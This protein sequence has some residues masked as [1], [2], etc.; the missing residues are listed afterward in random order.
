MN[1]RYSGSSKPE[2]LAK[3]RGAERSL[4]PDTALTW[5]AEADLAVN[6]L[7]NITGLGAAQALE[8]KTGRSFGPSIAMADLI[9]LKEG[10]DW[11]N[12]Y[13][14][15]LFMAA[16]EINQALPKSTYLSR[17][18]RSLMAQTSLMLHELRNLALP[19]DFTAFDRGNPERTEQLMQQAM[20]IIPTA[21][22]NYLY[23]FGNQI[24]IT[25]QQAIVMRELLKNPGTVVSHGQLWQ[26]LNQPSRQSYDKL[27]SLTRTKLS[28][29]GLEDVIDTIPTVGFRLDPHLN[30][31]WLLHR[32]YLSEK[33]QAATIILNNEFQQRIAEFPTVAYKGPVRTSVGKRERQYHLYEIKKDK[34]KGLIH[35]TAN[36]VKLFNLLLKHYGEGVT[37][38]RAEKET[39]M[40][41]KNLSQYIE[42]LEQKL[43]QLGMG[44][45]LLKT[46][47]LRRLELRLKPKE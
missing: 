9:H 3:I 11:V 40:S 6:Q 5:F 20:F 25:P 18:A 43:G 17:K 10:G 1:E 32:R 7:V 41:K 46:D 37:R 44:K 30:T 45:L 35:L 26:S 15:A 33:E 42:R 22:Q 19:A 14:G 16:S 8:L 36:E 34:H 23:A 13:A 31:H 28:Q 29:I 39:G 38:I 24:T 27:L 12:M 2:A 47:S 4:L 21:R